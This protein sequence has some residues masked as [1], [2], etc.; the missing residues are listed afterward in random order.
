MLPLACTVR[1]CRLPLA[2]RAGTLT[3]PRGHT[4]D[5][6]RSG[7]VNLL[8]PQDRRS[9]SPGDSKAA[10]AARGRLIESGVGREVFKQI[11]GRGATLTLVGDL[12]P[13]AAI[14][15]VERLLGEWTGEVPARVLGPPWPELP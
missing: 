8:Q 7:Y 10:V 9:P 12:D 14:G 6:A 4:Y 5:I 15:N 2:R 11:V 13:A 3:C 1:D